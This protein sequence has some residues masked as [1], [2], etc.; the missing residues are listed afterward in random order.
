M[1]KIL[2]LLLLSCSVLLAQDDFVRGIF[3]FD[4]V[5]VDFLQLRD[6]LN[7]NWIQASVDWY[8]GTKDTSV[9]NNSANLYIAS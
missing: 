4:K 8:D 9:L 5:S 3:L 7:L 6:S 2:I 1:K